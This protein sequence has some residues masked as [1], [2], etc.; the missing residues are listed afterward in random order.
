[1]KNMSLLNLGRSRPCDIFDIQWRF[2]CPDNLASS[3]LDRNPGD[4]SYLGLG[5][6]WRWKGFVCAWR[7]DGRQSSFFNFLDV[8]LPEQGCL[9]FKSRMEMD[10]GLSSERDFLIIDSL[11]TH[12]ISSWETSDA[13][14]R[15]NMFV[16]ANLALLDTKKSF[17]WKEKG[18]SGL[19]SQPAFRVMAL[20]KPC[21]WR[22]KLPGT[23]SE[24]ERI[25]LCMTTGWATDQPFLDVWLPEQGCSALESRMEMDWG[26][27]SEK[28]FRTNESLT[29]YFGSRET[30]DPSIVIICSYLPI[31]PML[32]TKKIRRVF[33]GRKKESAITQSASGRNHCTKATVLGWTQ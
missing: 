25:C 9:A 8:W 33:Y 28:D 1:M 16:P 2:A 4:W 3:S 12:Y 5:Q 7:P 15:Y 10:W 24:V 13:F 32:N 6:R 19:C 31:W 22:L 21:Q 26:S 29:R 17:L 23:G 14:H 20:S 27:S 18:M 30:S 11:T